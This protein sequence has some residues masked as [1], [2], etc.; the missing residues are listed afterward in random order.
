MC[1]AGMWEIEKSR[2]KWQIQ[3]PQGQ[4]LGLTRHMIEGWQP[5][6]QG[7]Y[8]PWDISWAAQLPRKKQPYMRSIGD[9]NVRSKEFCAK[10][11][12]GSEELR[13]QSADITKKNDL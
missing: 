8:G 9:E 5:F 1:N 6:N 13:D 7:A 10:A 2:K 11:V 3:G 4:Y 12:A